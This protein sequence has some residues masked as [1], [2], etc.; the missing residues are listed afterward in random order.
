M[1]IDPLN[2]SH[3]MT[4]PFLDPLKANP[5]LKLGDVRDAS[6]SSSA[7][8]HA[9]SLMSDELRSS[10]IS[11]DPTSVRT[12][13]TEAERSN[14]ANLMFKNE[15]GEYYGEDQLFF[16]QMPSAVPL[17]EAPVRPSSQ[18]EMSQV[19]GFK[20]TLSSLPSGC[21]GK[22]IIHKSGKVK[23]KIGDVLFDVST[24]MPCNFLQEV[25]AI[26]MDRKKYFQLG[27]ISR[28]MVCFPDIESLLENDAN[29]DQFRHNGGIK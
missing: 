25:V 19:L 21:I 15:E 18:T 10:S 20:G 9:S 13:G 26:N 14:P 16:I 4:L 12:M 1:A 22:L 23:L 11:L 24:G 29:E 27:D 8:A 6:S 17:G 3:P 28:R 5:N 2:L 7:H